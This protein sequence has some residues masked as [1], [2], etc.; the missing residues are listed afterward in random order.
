MTQGSAYSPETLPSELDVVIGGARVVRLNLLDE[1]DVLE[2]LSGATAPQVDIAEAAGETPIISKSGG[3]ITI[4][5]GGDKGVLEFTL[6]AA[7]TGL[8]SVGTYVAQAQVTIGGN[9]YV[10][11][12]TYV[13]VTGKVV[14]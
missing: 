10:T 1:N 8:L 11:K 6:S 3:D 4:E 9:D 5:P 14:P 2:D 12:P 13:K 7:D